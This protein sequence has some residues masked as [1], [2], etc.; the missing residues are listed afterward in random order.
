MIALCSPYLN[1]TLKNL[2]KVEK[3]SMILM[4]LVKLQFKDVHDVREGFFT[5]FTQNFKNSDDCSQ[6]KE[7]FL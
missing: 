6:L 3:F 4:E 2:S 1:V 5:S 7:Q